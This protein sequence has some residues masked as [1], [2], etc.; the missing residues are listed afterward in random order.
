M[1]L[2]NLLTAIITVT[3]IA[4]VAAII[5]LH[6]LGIQISLNGGHRVGNVDALQGRAVTECARPDVGHGCGDVDRLPG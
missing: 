5:I 2:L 1:I 3:T 6:T 4:I